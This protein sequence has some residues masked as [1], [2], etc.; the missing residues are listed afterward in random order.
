MSLTPC[1]LPREGGA[2]AVSAKQHHSQPTRRL[3]RRPDTRISQ[4]CKRLR[5]PVNVTDAPSLCSFTLPALYAD[6]PVQIGITTSGMGCKLA[7]RI[8]RHVLATLPANLGQGVRRLGS[9]RRRLI[10]E[11][12]TPVDEG[13]VS[14]EEEEEAAGAQKADFNH[15]LGTSSPKHRRLRWLAQICEHWP[16]HRLANISDADIDTLLASYASS[17]TQSPMRL[18]QTPRI[19]LAGAGPGSPHLLTHA[20]RRAIETAS[21]IL[22]DKLVP[23]AVLDLIP[24]RT[25]V[26][27]A[28]KFPGNADKAQAQLL[29]IGLHALQ[30][31]HTVLRLKQGDPYIY[32]RGGEEVLFFRAAGYE[33][34]VLP[35]LTS[36][37]VA[38]LTAGIPL[39]HRGVADQVRVCTGVGRKGASPVPP[40]YVPGQTVVVL[41]VLNR[42]ENFVA[43]LVGHAKGAD[44]EDGDGSTAADVPIYASPAWPLHTPCAI[45]ERASSPDQRVLRSSLRHIVRAYRDDAGSRPPGLLILGRACE[46]LAKQPVGVGE[47]G[48]AS[49]ANTANT[50]N[51]SH[52]LNGIDRSSGSS[53]AHYV[54]SPHYAN[55]GTAAS[56]SKGANGADNARSNAADTKTQ[57]H[58]NTSTAENPPDHAHLPSPPEYTLEEGWPAL[59][60]WMQEIDLQAALQGTALTLDDGAC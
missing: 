31:G 52:G 24:R 44:K 15:Q 33:P 41:M 50:V 28:E 6:G 45:V 37:L 48:E 59:D 46:V 11:E 53:N 40:G 1:S 57:E 4:L 49:R 2:R 3:T 13:D 5:I 30:R 22:T 7:A 27:I 12:R 35:G 56:E 8:R 17:V 54:N 26:H 42:L 18:A 32:G 14:E 21:L 9:M 23:S 39:T 60:T 29:D 25:P 51:V 38:P 20:T 47:A 43:S 10:D 55:S 58:A 16:L 19:I 34:L 36:A